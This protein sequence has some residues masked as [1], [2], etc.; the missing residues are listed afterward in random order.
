MKLIHLFLIVAGLAS[1]TTN[2]TGEGLTAPTSTPVKG[3][4]GDAGVQG[5]KGDPGEA[6]PAG[7]AGPTGATGPQGPQGF[8]G[9]PGAPGPQG[10]QGL[11]G[12]ASAKGDPGPA[13]PMGPAG[14]QGPQG[15]P[16]QAGPAG[17]AGPKGDPG[18]GGAGFTKANLYSPTPTWSNGSKLPAGQEG[19]IT[20]TC[21]NNKDI[22]LTG[23]CEVH[24][25]G[26]GWILFSGA[27]NNGTELLTSSWQC[28]FV[29]ADGAGTPGSYVD[30]GGSAWCLKVP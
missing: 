28:W 5:P 23:H 20:W 22:M 11:P 1:C 18:T 25:S 13:G 8:K 19:A 9:D 10:P 24:G 26:H 16:G 12:T 29:N 27:V 30:I 3:P 6:G 14:P 7:P 17:P 2:T 4:A 15:I 21:D